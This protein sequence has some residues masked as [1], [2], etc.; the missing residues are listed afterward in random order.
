MPE[1]LKSIIKEIY[2]LIP[3]KKPFFDLLKLI[4]IPQRSFYRF[5]VHRKPFNIF[6]GNKKLTIQHP[7]FHFYIE[8]EFY[9]KGYDK[10]NFEKISRGLWTKLAEK[11]NTIIDIGAN[12]GLYSLLANL[13]NPQSQIFAFEPI[14]RNVEKLKINC[15]LN[16]F[17]NIA[18]ID[19]AISN[20]DGHTNIYQPKT[21]VSTISTLNKHIAEERHVEAN[22]E[23]VETIRLDTFIKKNDFKRIDLIK[24]DVEGY[25]VPVFE[26]MGEYIKSMK[27]TI[28]AEI[29]IE[30]NGARIMELLGDCGYLFFDID[31]KNPPK[32]VSE[33]TKSSNN[34]F[35]ICTREIAQYLKLPIKNDLKNSQ[36]KGNK[37]A[38]R[39]TTFTKFVQ[40]YDHYNPVDYIIKKC[41]TFSN[42]LKLRVI[43]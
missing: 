12:T 42:N 2:Y 40:F 4:Y 7:G 30:E 35:L 36:S 38:E 8:N 10:S 6:V 11:S 25:E 13:V 24:I 23:D 21:D 31:E 26:G 9:W 16:Q 43:H 32:P 22:V 5:M 34:N 33:I 1:K 39:G 15:A 29:R 19:A 18:I 14:K 17:H 3:L 20:T 41:N 28:L 37:S 27:P